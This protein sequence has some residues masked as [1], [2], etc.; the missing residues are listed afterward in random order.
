MILSKAALLTALLSRYSRDEEPIFRS[1]SFGKLEETERSFFS[2]PLRGTAVFPLLYPSGVERSTE[3][4]TTQ[5]PGGVERSREATLPFA[6][7]RAKQSGTFGTFG[8]PALPK[9]PPSAPSLRYLRFRRDRRYRCSVSAV[10][11][12]EGAEGSVP[13]VHRRSAVPSVK[14]GI[15]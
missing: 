14:Q 7:Q 6:E 8:S 13:S 11:S 12:T 4:R 5:Y 9:V 3:G 15:R 1:A 2:L 10:R